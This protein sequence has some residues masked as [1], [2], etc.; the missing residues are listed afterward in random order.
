MEN[1]CNKEISGFLSETEPYIERIDE[2]S[3]ETAIELYDLVSDAAHVADV[4]IDSID[5]MLRVEACSRLD[6]LLERIVD[7][8]PTFEHSGDPLQ[9][10]APAVQFYRRWENVE[11]MKDCGLVGYML[12]KEIKAVPIMLFGT[13]PEDYPYL[14]ELPQMKMLYNDS[15]PGQPDVYYDH[16][17]ENF[18]E[19]DILLLYGMYSH[20]VDYLDVYRK[21]RPDGKVYCGLDMNSYW[22]DTTPWQSTEARRFARQCDVIA[23]SCRSM[24]DALNKNPHVGFPCRW[25]TNGFYNPTGIPVIAEPEKKE[26]I[27][28]TVGRIGTYQKN[29]EELLTAFANVS[30]SLKDWSLCFVGSI[31]PGFQEY[32]DSYYSKYPHLKDRVIFKGPVFDKE[33]LYNEYARAKIFILTSR[34]EGFPNVYA[35]ALFHGCMFITSDI[36]AADD[37]TNFGE[38]GLVY[39]LHDINALQN[40]LAKLC[41][42]ADT[43]YIKEHIPKALRYARKYYDWERNAKKLTYMLY[44]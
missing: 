43:N 30:K 20:S 9:I 8:F 35:E 21:Q 6:M 14:S 16:L 29:N 12:A 26:N 17:K 39:P 11:L 25:F 44:R 3:L 42:K 2:L 23:T 13:K 15:E 22:M 31:E 19:M 1:T 27:I 24:R 38:L 7:D 34:Q 37:M 40:A 41:S 28:L 4:H 32:I 36:D 10:Y 18:S 33:A 5:P